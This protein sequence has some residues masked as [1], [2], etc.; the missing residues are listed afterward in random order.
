MGY[1]TTF[2]L[3]WSRLAG[4]NRD[5]YE[6]DAKIAVAIKEANDKDGSL[7]GVTPEGESMDSCKWYDHEKDMKA[8]SKK[9]PNVLFTLHGEGEEAGDVWNKY[10]VNGKMQ[11]ARATIA[12]APFDKDKLA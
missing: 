11:V 7:Y 5:E 8:F 12:I 3:T 1:C 9:F 4:N 2:S 10:F 6:L